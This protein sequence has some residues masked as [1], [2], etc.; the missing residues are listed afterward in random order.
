M[1]PF[2]KRFPDEESAYRYFHDKRWPSGA[3]CPYCAS[4]DVRDVAN[5]KPMPH[6]CN[7]C[8]KYFSVR[9]GTPMAGDNRPLLTWLSASY[10]LSLCPGNMYVT[11]L[12]RFIKAK[13][14][15]A[16]HLMDEIQ[17]YGGGAFRVT[18][19]DMIVRP[20]LERIEP[21]EFTDTSG[22]AKAYSE[23]EHANEAASITY[24]E[25]RHTYKP[26][27]AEEAFMRQ[28]TGGTGK[29]FDCVLTGICLGLIIT[30]AAAGNTQAAWLV[31]ALLVIKGMF[32]IGSAIVA[33]RKRS[34][35]G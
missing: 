26:N 27:P 16:K 20:R 24:V 6:A 25:Q 13:P 34:A 2:H 33:S 28:L 1:R 7:I 11:K 15:T 22:A 23:E 18:A 8:K 30:F 21:K 4:P 32:S 14:G 9:E 35:E 29:E 31:L 10:V 19:E 3:S 12:G 17:G 5:R